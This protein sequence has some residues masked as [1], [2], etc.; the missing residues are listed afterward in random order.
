[1]L[2]RWWFWSWSSRA[3]GSRVRIKAVVGYD[4]TGYGG[5]QRQ[6]NAPTIQAEIED[7]LAQLTRVPTR[8]L[9]AGRTDAGV[10]AEGQV[11]AFDTGWRHPV[12]ELQRGMNALLS[13]QVAVFELDEVNPGFHPRFDAISRHY[14]YSIYRAAVRHPFYARYSLHVEQALDVEAMSRAAQCLLGSHDFLAFGSPPQGDNSIRDVIRAGWSVEGA[15]LHFDIE[16]NAF[17]YRMV[18]MVVGTLL[19]VGSGALTPESFAEILETRSREQ[20][21]PA[22]AAD[23]LCL[24]SVA[25]VSGRGTA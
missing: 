11:I 5:F 20:A 2:Q 15:W 6:E 19:R 9:A 23:G 8:V 3:V 7:V 18:R 25:Y 21:G 17:L 24:K 22:V 14:Q 1:M 16:A 4:G 13:R 10:H 12:A